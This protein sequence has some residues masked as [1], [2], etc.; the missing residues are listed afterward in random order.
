[1]REEGASFHYTPRL[2]KNFPMNS[3]GGH[4][5]DMATGNKIDRITG[6]N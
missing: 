1:M 4:W 2:P 5:V 3:M 6:C